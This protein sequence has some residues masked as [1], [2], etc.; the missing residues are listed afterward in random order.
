MKEASGRHK[1]DGQLLF[2]RDLTGNEVKIQSY[3]CKTWPDS[4]AAASGVTSAW[5]VQH[6][7]MHGTTLADEVVLG[8]HSSQFMATTDVT[9]GR[10]RDLAEALGSGPRLC[11]SLPLV[12]PP[13]LSPQEPVRFALKTQQSSKAAQEER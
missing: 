2:H 9:A 4:P 12:A 1:A 10:W 7:E 13:G 6:L 8:E 3:S 5:R 11:T